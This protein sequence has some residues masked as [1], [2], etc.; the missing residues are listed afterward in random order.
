M[1][2]A[3]AWNLESGISTEASHYNN[4]HEAVQHAVQKLKERLKNE[5]L[6]CE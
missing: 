1:F 2:D 5:G 6:L 3:R 4:S